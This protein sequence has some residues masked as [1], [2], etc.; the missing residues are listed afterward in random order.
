[1]KISQIM[2][3]VLQVL[4]VRRCN[5]GLHFFNVLLAISLAWAL[6]KVRRRNIRRYYCWIEKLM[7]RSNCALH[8][9]KLIYH[10]NT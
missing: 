6:R 9:I 7:G 1:M 8:I 10:F 5:V 2:V 3:L 4:P